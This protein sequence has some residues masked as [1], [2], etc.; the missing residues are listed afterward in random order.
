MEQRDRV[1]HEQ[2]ALVRA[3]VTTAP[4]PPELDLGE[5][6][7]ADALV[8]KRVRQAADQW[9]QLARC[10]GPGFRRRFTAWAVDHPVPSGVRNPWADGLVFA[11][12]DVS[13]DELDTD[14]LVERQQGRTRAVLRGGR[15]AGTAAE[16]RRRRAPLL[17]VGRSRTHRWGRR[18][19]VITL[20][21]T[22]GRP[23]TWCIPGR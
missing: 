16:V 7:V 4:R 23:R 19:T 3:L 2:D 1:D 9:P 14:G 17:L 5:V 20:S 12:R 21:V 6:S 13:T 18:R 8:Q 22:P 15:R 11:L 10:L